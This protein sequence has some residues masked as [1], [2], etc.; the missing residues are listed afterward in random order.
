[1]DACRFIKQQW[2]NKR[3]AHIRQLL[4]DKH[5]VQHVHLPYADGEYGEACP[6]RK[7]SCLETDLPTGVSAADGDD[8]GWED[9]DVL[10]NPGVMDDAGGQSGTSAALSGTVYGA[11][12]PERTGRM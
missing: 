4:S 2:E 1:M 12:A 5:N 7:I 10:D 9:D 3:V 11:D 8:D 6:G